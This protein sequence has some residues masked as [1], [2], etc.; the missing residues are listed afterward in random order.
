MDTFMASE[1]FLEP[2][3]ALRPSHLP[4]IRL[5]C[6]TGLDELFAHMADGARLLA[7]GTD[8]LLQAGQRGEPDCLVW[9]GGIAAMK[10][11]DA[12]GEIIRVG[13]AVPMAS[14]IRSRS[15]RCGAPAVADGARVVGSPQLRNQATMVGNVCT[16]SPA[17]DT[18]P[19][20][21]VHDCL[22]E[23][24]NRENEPR[25]VAL[26]DFTVGPATTVLGEGE[27]VTGLMLSRLGRNETSAY[28]RFTYRKALDL[29]FVGVAARL[30]YEEDGQTLK[31][32]RLALGAVGPTVIDAGAAT[33]ILTG[34]PLDE[35]RL[36][37]CADAASQLCEPIS[38]HRASA[39]YRRQLIGA[40]VGDVVRQAAE[41]HGKQS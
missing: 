14:M 22:V 18:V 4:E 23:I 29:A 25:R 37:I 13:A 15:F 27:L 1:Y 3:S 9:T 6:P 2:A 20:L 32:V 12:Q 30:D 17:A 33:D 24:I 16:A 34:H 11:F 19:G 31:S 10:E 40:L 41:R 36:R 8:I 38:D 21:L 7:G 5:D 35:D 26:K 39:G 28:Q